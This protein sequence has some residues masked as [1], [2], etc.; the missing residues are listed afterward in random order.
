MDLSLLFLLFSSVVLLVGWG[1]GAI[2]ILLF[3]QLVALQN[4]NLSGPMLFLQGGATAGLA[5][6]GSAM[7]PRTQLKSRHR[8][9]G[10]Q[11]EVTTQYTN[12]YIILC[13]I[14][15]YISSFCWSRYSHL[16]LELYC[17]CQVQHVL[18]KSLQIFDGLLWKNVPVKWKFHI[19]LI[20][21]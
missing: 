13:Y 7:S 18:F 10:I 1:R 20:V 4:S 9:Q 19:P 6:L 11:T 5:Q 16:L 3:A 21:C 14:S 15:Y 12:D 2:G 17:C 8:P